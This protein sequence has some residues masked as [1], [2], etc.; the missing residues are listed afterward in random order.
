MRCIIII[1]ITFLMLAFPVFAQ[2]LYIEGSL[3]SE[4]YSTATQTLTLDD[5]N[6]VTLMVPLTCLM[7]YGKE[8]QVE[9]TYT[10]LCN[11]LSAEELQKISTCGFF[12][13]FVDDESCDKL[14]EKL[15]PERFIEENKEDN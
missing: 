12:C 4:D 6:Y 5:Y 10:E 8:L 9:I 2:E 15:I 11:D 3:T 13:R 14:I 1:S 7:I